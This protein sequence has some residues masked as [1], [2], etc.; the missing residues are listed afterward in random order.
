MILGQTTHAEQAGKG[1]MAIFDGLMRL[2]F[3]TREEFIGSLESL[4]TLQA[5]AAVALGIW[6]LFYGY[7]YFKAMVIINGAASGSLIGMYVSQIFFADAAP[8]TPLLMSL[9]GAVLLGALAW[10]M[11]KFTVGIMGALA[12]GIIGYA[13]WNFACS[14]LANE[15][16]RQLAWVGGIIGMIVVGM[17]AFIIFRVSVMIFTG[18]QG[19]FMTVGGVISLLLANAS[20]RESIRPAMVE[21][22]LLMMILFGVPA[23]IGFAIQYSTDAAAARKKNKS[24][25]KAPA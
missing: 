9:G 16:M 12:G 8:N 24:A 18:L 5:A 17:V 19:A 3:P 22:N 20:M 1:L 21:N 15:S 11:M 25:D 10:P 6:Y 7:K 4:T 13:A 23:A 14:I 2:Q